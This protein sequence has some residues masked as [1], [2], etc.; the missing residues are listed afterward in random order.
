MKLNYKKLLIIGGILLGFTNILSAQNKGIEY[1]S[2]GMYETAKYYLLK[3]GA[4]SEDSYYL[5][6]VYIIENKLDS[7]AYFFKKIKDSE[8]ANPLGY[9]GEG[10]TALLKNNVPFAEQLFDQ[11][12]KQDKKN[13]ETYVSIAKAYGL[14]EQNEKMA[15]MLEKA[16]KAKKNYP[17]IFLAEGDVLLKK[18]NFGEAISKYENALYFDKQNKEALLKLAQVYLNVNNKEQVLSY[19]DNLLAIDPDY[20]PAYVVAADAYYSLGRYKSSIESFEKFINEPGISAK[21]HEKYASVLFFSKEYLKSLEQ[22]DIALKEDPNAF[23]LNRLKIYNLYE[24]GNYEEA[25][26]IATKFLESKESKN[27]YIWQDYFYYGQLLSKKGED[28]LAI[29]NYEKALSMD[30][31]R[32]EINKEISASYEKLERHDESIAYFQKYIDATPD[33]S[34]TDKFSFGRTCYYA[35][36]GKISSNQNGDVVLEADSLKGIEYL[37][38][39]DKSFKE[40]SELSPDSYLGYFWRA[41]VNSVLD[42]E[43]TQGLAKPYYEK[44]LSILS[45]NPKGR[46]PMLI[47]CYKYLGYY[48]Y[49]NNDKANAIENFSKVVELDPTDEAIKEAIK[50]IKKS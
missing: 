18:Q 11:A 31:K 1:F 30:S 24:L 35:G 7:A 25:M 33:L 42:P 2:A 15:E 46:E 48:Y 13:P 49:I 3:S 12:I 41:R 17:G 6:E 29:V 19:I 38:M 20:I 50:E 21:E 4:S 34:V 37:N 36:Y 47:E 16:G 9:I 45:Q 43:S 22:I 8:P 27:E 28:S 39:A 10:K 23:I 14:A 40:V 44:A 32:T 5:G 26:N